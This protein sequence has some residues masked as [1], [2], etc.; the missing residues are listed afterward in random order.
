M[1]LANVPE[2]ISSAR[3]RA[4]AAR[5]GKLAE[6]NGKN[7]NLSKEDWLNAALAVLNE[8]G[9]NAVKVLPLSKRLGV[10]RGSFYWHFDDRDELLREVLRHWDEELTGTVIAHASG[11][12]VSPREKLQDVLTN[13]LLNRRN[14]YDTAISAWGA[15][16]EEAAKVYNR[17]IRKRLRF[18][19]T[20]LAEAGIEKKEAAF[21]ARLVLGFVLSEVGDRGRRSKADMQDDVKRCCDIIFA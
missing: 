16:D 20:I 4:R 8:E 19:S 9:V 2:G 12:E 15:F 18:L 7:G 14:I 17:V 13:V 11:L 21:R 1:S 6:S 5:A 10:T 3:R